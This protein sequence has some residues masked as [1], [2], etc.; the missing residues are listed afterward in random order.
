MAKKV[1]GGT[2]R[3]SKLDEGIK[4]RKRKERG[5]KS[6]WVGFHNSASPIKR[7]RAV[8]ARSSLALHQSSTR[9]MPVRGKGEGH[10]LLYSVIRGKQST[11]MR[12]RIKSSKVSLVSRV[13]GNLITSSYLDPGSLP[14]LS[15]TRPTAFAAW[16][17]CDRSSGCAAV[18]TGRSVEVAVGVASNVV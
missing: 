4:G 13:S 11:T 6:L 17:T 8:T 14:S 7:E 9:E 10:E 5:H 3:T 1:G 18:V 2:K 15:S 16:Y 12:K